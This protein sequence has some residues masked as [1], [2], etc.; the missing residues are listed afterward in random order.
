MPGAQGASGAQGIPGQP[1]Q[2]GPPGIASV[3][4]FE[5]GSAFVDSATSQRV[6]AFVATGSGNSECLT[7]INDST[8]PGFGTTDGPYCDQVIHNG[9]QG[10]ELTVLLAAPAPPDLMIVITAWQKDANSYPAPVP[11]DGPC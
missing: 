6:D 5:L 9:E 11:C 2:P 3:G 10:L 4:R 1:G 7:T 8:V